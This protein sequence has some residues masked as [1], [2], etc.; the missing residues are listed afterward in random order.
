LLSAI[1]RLVFAG[2]YHLATEVLDAVNI[3]NPQTSIR[4]HRA[5]F[6]AWWR[7]K[8]SAARRSIHLMRFANSF[9]R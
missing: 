1:D 3:L 5:G 7:W 2:L 6:Q 9:V 4:G 8:S